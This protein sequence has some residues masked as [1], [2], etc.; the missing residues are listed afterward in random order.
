MSCC[1]EILDFLEECEESDQQRGKRCF[2]EI[3]EE[4][5]T[6]HENH[7]KKDTD[8]EKL[9][10]ITNNP[11]FTI[12]QDEEGAR[13]S[14]SDYGKGKIKKCKVDPTLNSS[15]G[16]GYLRWIIGDTTWYLAGHKDGVIHSVKT[17]EITKLPHPV[18]T[19]MRRI[20]RALYKGLECYL[21]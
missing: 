8:L 5:Y 9:R 3:C 4:Q 17:T 15:S 20:G 19:D 14:S 6:L 7:K 18:P 13:P 2:S 1:S 16:T 12:L 10:E 11:T 21:D